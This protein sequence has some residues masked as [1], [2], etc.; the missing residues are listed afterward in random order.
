MR[1]RRLARASAAA[2]ARDK[3]VTIQALTEGESDSGFPTE[4]EWADLATVAMAREDLEAVERA[5]TEQDLALTTT[6]WQMAYRADMDPERIDVPKLRRLAYLGRHYD[7]LA[8]TPVG[9]HRV[10]EL[11]TEVHSQVEA[12]P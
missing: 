5:R 12:A 2:G 4:D 1:Y 9:R 6:S 11:L 8:A 7:I 10:L 3:W